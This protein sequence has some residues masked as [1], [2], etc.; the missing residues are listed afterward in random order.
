MSTSSAS[1]RSMSVGLDHPFPRLKTATSQDVEIYC[2]EYKSGASYKGQVQDN[3]RVGKGT[4]VWPKGGRYE[5]EFMD[6]VRH[7]TG[8]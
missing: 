1:E 8:V 6:N 5:G 3:K 2:K 4:F 7:G